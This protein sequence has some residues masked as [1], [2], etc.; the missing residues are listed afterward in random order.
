[1]N[2]DKLSLCRQQLRE[3]NGGINKISR[4]FSKFFIIFLSKNP[5]GAIIVNL[6]MDDSVFEQIP[7]LRTPQTY[8][9]L[10]KDTSWK[11]IRQA[12]PPGS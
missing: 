10:N 4:T 9:S 1:M 11:I 7:E 5:A 3:I 8:L 12:Y 6:G 2:P